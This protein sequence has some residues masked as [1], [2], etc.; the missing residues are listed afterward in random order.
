M[1]IKFLFDRTFAFIGI[2]LFSPLYILLSLIIFL[3]M[4]DG[5]PIFV[6]RRVGRQG[7]TF[8]MYK[9]RTMHKHHNGS[10]VSVKGESRITPL[11]A[12]LRKWKLDELPELW[13]VWIGDM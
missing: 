10:S 12:F 13:N 3:S 5:S 6:Q 11:G 8:K 1:C 9:F 2:I 7:K 4:P